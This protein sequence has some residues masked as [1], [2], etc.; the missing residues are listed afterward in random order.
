MEKPH[1]V[2]AWLANQQ[3]ERLADY[4]KRGRPFA[5]SPIDELRT[6]WVMLMN[7][8]ARSPADFDHSERED[9]EAELQVREVGPPIELAEDAIETLRRKS[10]AHIL[11]D[12]ERFNRMADELDDEVARFEESTKGKKN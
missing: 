8:W 10:R 3:L 6:R 12:R 1:I 9:I 7:G 2:D 4:L 11:Q 5:S